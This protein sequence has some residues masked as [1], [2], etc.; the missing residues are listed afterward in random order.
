MNIDGDAVPGGQDAGIPGVVD[1]PV[2]Q[3]DA[4]G[5]NVVFGEIVNEVGGG[6]HARVNNGGMFAVNQHITIGFIGAGGKT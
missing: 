5:L 1:M 4:F 2:S 6:V 3:E